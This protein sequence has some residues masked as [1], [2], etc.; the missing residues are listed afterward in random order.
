VSRDSAIFELAGEDDEGAR[1]GEDDARL[2]QRQAT[3]GGRTELTL[4]SVVASFAFTIGAGEPSGTTHGKHH[5][6]NF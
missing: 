6:Y 4:A 2:W 3:I 5:H 1:D